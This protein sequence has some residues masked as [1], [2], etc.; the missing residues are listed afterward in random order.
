MGSFSKLQVGA[1]R[2]SEPER[3]ALQKLDEFIDAMNVVLEDNAIAN[4]TMLIDDVTRSISRLSRTVLV[5]AASRMMKLQLDP[6]SDA[7]H[8]GLGPVGQGHQPPSTRQ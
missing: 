2:L 1:H 8:V 6:E 7:S 5:A 3:A 4:D